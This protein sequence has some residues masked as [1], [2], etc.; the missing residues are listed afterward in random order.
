MT[1][2]SIHL[3]K[4]LVKVF[5]LSSFLIV[6]SLSL[7]VEKDWS[8][9]LKPCWVKNSEINYNYL[10][11]SDNKLKISQINPVAVLVSNDLIVGINSANGNT[12]WKSQIAGTIISEPKVS[13]NSIFI[14]SKPK[15]SDKVNAIDKSEFEN[16][17]VYL[18]SINIFS[19][20]SNWKIKFPSA[21]EIFIN[22][23]NTENT[24][25]KELYILS[26]KTKLSLINTL[27]NE[28]IWTK[29]F[30]EEIMLVFPLSE[31][32]LVSTKKNE[33][34]II[35]SKDG[36]ILNNRKNKELAI[37]YKQNNNKAN[38]NIFSVGESGNIINTNLDTDKIIWQRKIGGKVSNINFYDNTLFIS[39]F[40]N[41][42]YLFNKDTGKLLLKK[43]LDGR[44]VNKVSQQD[45][46]IAVSAYNSLQ[47][48]LF[49]LKTIKEVNFLSLSDA[50][51][52][53]EH[54]VFS[55]KFLIIATPKNIIAFS[56][57]C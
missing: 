40:D 45:N 5:L 52:F 24:E 28:I 1:H 4:K 32:V 6:P 33:I 34:L 56:F 26:E 18:T 21:T 53:I 44:I 22:T 41:F 29:N 55:E 30:A 38:N 2:Y 3:L 48:T 25:K 15:I 31:K 39:S 11:A 35:S 54:F 50:D 47:I 42:V 37:K 57:D 17:T 7:E 27:N 20:L 23:E 13:D 14:L 10:F 49:N 9:S 16:E 19:G 46:I 8:N 51:V 12:I 43:R 36:K